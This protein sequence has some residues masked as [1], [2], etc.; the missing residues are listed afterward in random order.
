MSQLSPGVEHEQQDG[1]PLSQVPVGLI[2]RGLMAMLFAV[3]VVAGLHGYLGLRLVWEPGWGQPWTA[4]GL[5]ALGLL[6]ASIPLGFMAS[7]WR[8]TWLNR[9]L[10]WTSML[11][12]GAFGLLLSATVVADL[13]GGVWRLVGEVPD[14]LAFARTKALGVLAVVVPALGFAFRTARGRARVERIQIPMAHLGPG[15]HGARVVQISDVHIGPTLDRHFLQRVVDQVNALKPDL[16][17]VT[18]DLVDGSVRALREEMTPLSGLKA[19][20]GVYYVTGNHEYYHGG[21]AWSAEVARLGLTVLRNEHRVVERA[22]ARLTVAGVTDVEGGRVD[23][24]HMCRPDLALAGAPER[25][26]RLLLAH[27]PR[28]A[29]LARGLGVDLQLSGHTHGGQ[30]F[31]FMFLVKLQQPVIRGLAMIAGVRVYT[32]RGTGYWGPPL[33]LGPAP[34]IA[35]V[36]LVAQ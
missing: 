7:R 34:E 32:H 11:W 28:A 10:Y 18:G 13:L 36:T 29:F 5:G 19:P 1:I 30:L 27:Q 4:L 20:L 25:V 14:A 6:F 17:A 16:I 26:P 22:G 9:A 24:S 23:P 33:R 21:A 15:L 35:E 12:L 2:I 3:G 8:P 31:P